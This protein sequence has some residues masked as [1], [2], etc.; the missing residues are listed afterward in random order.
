[1]KS[2]GKERREEGRRIVAVDRNG[3]WYIEIHSELS[4]WPCLPFYG[5][6]FDSYTDAVKAINLLEGKHE[7]ADTSAN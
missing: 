4:R 2:N 6:S 7:T 5:E 3:R 1:M